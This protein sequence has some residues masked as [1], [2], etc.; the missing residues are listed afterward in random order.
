MS[1]G[2]LD[3]LFSK[4]PEELFYATYSL[5]QAEKYLIECGAVDVAKD[6]R[7]LIEY[8]LSARN[9]IEVMQENLREVFKAIEWEQS[10]DSGKDRVDRAI[11]AYRGESQ[12][13]IS[14][15]PYEEKD[16]ECDL[17]EFKHECI[18]IDVTRNEDTRTH[19][20]S[21]MGNICKKHDPT[22]A[23]NEAFRHIADNYNLA[24]S[25]DVKNNTYKFTMIDTDNATTGG[26][27]GRA[28]IEIFSVAE[29]FN[30]NVDFV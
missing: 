7:R 8:V 21:A 26:I 28:R 3:Y 2:S 11:A 22:L 24:W 23:I 1:G 25:F 13:D 15:E 9:R 27:P 6:V 12:N 19:M 16:T 17:C 5:E 29:A 10:G 4:E 30:V 14:K 18:L 20:R